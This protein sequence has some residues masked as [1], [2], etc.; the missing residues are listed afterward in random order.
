[1]RDKTITTVQKHYENHLAPIYV[2]MAGGFDTALLRAE[3][4]VDVVS[5]QSGRGLNAVDLGSGFGVH[6][7]ALA[8]Q[9]YSVIAMDTSSLLLDVV[10]PNI[11]TLPIRLIQDDLLEFPQYIE[12]QV[13]LVLCMGDT[14][15][16]LSTKSMV[17]ELFHSVSVAL[18][19][20]GKFIATFRDYTLPL[21]DERRFVPVKNDDDRILTCFL[22]YSDEHVTVNDVLYER[23]ASVWNLR[24]SAYKKL[25]LSREWVVLMLKDLGFFV[26]VEPGEAGLL[27]VVAT[28][29]GSNN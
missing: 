15:T 12:S 8:R 24:V 29:L 26:F 18:Q 2:W 13:A 17:E 4:D 20:G 10:R 9:G 19:A 6:A 22:E 5:N 11:G 27:R 3:R 14:L 21:T 23:E 16:H 7:I 28:K 1:M 25:R